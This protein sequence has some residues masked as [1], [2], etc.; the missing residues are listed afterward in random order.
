M[1]GIIQKGI[2]LPDPVF[3]KALILVALSEA[4][5]IPKQTWSDNIK[6][7]HVPEVLWKLSITSRAL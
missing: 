3:V 7:S 2:W 6:N 1:G 5:E 4:E